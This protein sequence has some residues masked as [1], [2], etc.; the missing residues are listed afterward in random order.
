MSL[1]LCHEAFPTALVQSLVASLQ[2]E[3]SVAGYEGVLCSGD[4]SASAS[5]AI[6]RAAA[7]LVVISPAYCTQPSSKRDVE[8]AVSSARALVPILLPGVTWPLT[9]AMGKFAPVLIRHLGALQPY[10]ADFLGAGLGAAVVAELEARGVA[11]LASSGVVGG[12][13]GGGAGGGGGGARRASTLDFD[14]LE[15]PA[16]AATPLRRATFSGPSSI[17]S[18]GGGGGGDTFFASN[19]AFG[20]RL[21]PSPAGGAA[22]KASPGGAAAARRTFSAAE[23]LD[24][25]DVTVGGAGRPRTVEALW[26]GGSGLSNARAS[27]PGRAATFSGAAGG[28]EVNSLAPARGGAPSV[29]AAGTGGAPSAAAMQRARAAQRAATFSAVREETDD[30]S[31]GDG[32]DS[33]SDSAG[34]ATRAAAKADAAFEGRGGAR[35]KLAAA[36]RGGRSSDDDDES[37]EE[38]DG[39]GAGKGKAEAAATA[40]PPER[41]PAGRGGKVVSSSAAAAAEAAALER[42]RA[43]EERTRALEAAAAAAEA[44]RAA[45][46]VA[47]AEAAAA[48]TETAALE[49]ARAAE[50]RTRAL[51]AAA[52]ALREA[53][54]NEASEVTRAEAA[55]VG[56]GGAISTSPRARTASVAL[57]LDDAGRGGDG[58]GGGGGRDRAASSA[59]AAAPAPPALSSARPV[60]S[61]LSSRLPGESIHGYCTCTLLHGGRVSSLVTVGGGVVMSGGVDGTPLRAWDAVRGRGVAN[62]PVR[63]MSMS[64]LPGGRLAVGLDTLV[65]EIWDLRRR[66]RLGVLRGHSGGVTSLALVMPGALLVSGSL[67]KTARV[68]DLPNG[69]ACV[70]TLEGHAATVRGVAALPDGRVATCSHDKTVRI[71]VVPPRSPPPPPLPALRPPTSEQLAWHAKATAEAGKVSH[72][73]VVAARARTEVLDHGAPVN[74]VVVVPAADGGTR[75]LAAAADFMVY[76]WTLPRGGGA[77]SLLAQLQG[78]S[79]RVHALVALPGGLVASG[80]DDAM[81]RVWDVE[82]L[83][84]VAVLKGHNSGVAC[85]AALP[86]GRLVSATGRQDGQARVWALCKPGSAEDIAACNEENE[87]RTVEPSIEPAGPPPPPGG[88]APTSFVW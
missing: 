20:A 54:A 42:A 75:L 26:G 15:G 66:E 36:T 61:P 47:A 52:A 68:W 19:A 62:L 37:S 24:F 60:E 57:P 72:A 18:G 34:A 32:S 2:T 58:V 84:Q 4:R 48:A 1:F 59:A 86:G 81:V 8:L 70:L 43:A 16:P 80:G 79:N 39:G 31:E 44:K 11:P 33:E 17:S 29:P 12:W 88:S 38:E 85:I 25:G 30:S 50:E 6:P 77:A 35:K 10:S 46:E 56:G 87:E 64:A 82:T 40:V 45:A 83:S 71:W 69:A 7:V 49:R 67:D 65:V 78:H 22:Q 63:A 5:T 51:A 28:G 74:A 21:A 76:L 41:K 14:D 55:R 23:E 13:Y 53:A 73:A 9:P 27:R 3:L